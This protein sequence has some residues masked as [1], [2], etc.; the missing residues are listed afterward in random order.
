M[1]TYGQLLFV[2][3]LAV[4]VFILLLIR[5]RRLLPGDYT[6]LKVIGGM[7][8]VSLAQLYAGRIFRLDW[9]TLLLVVAVPLAIGGALIGA[10]QAVDLL[11]RQYDRVR[12][13]IAEARRT[14]Q[15]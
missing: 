13:Q 1:L 6:V 12:D 15:P 5:W 3:A 8:L 10:W 9:M 11:V 14:R 2:L 4:A 7:A